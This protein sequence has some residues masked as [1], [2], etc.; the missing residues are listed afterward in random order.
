MSF[1][2]IT[3]NI[4]KNR[5]LHTVIPF[6]KKEK[7]DVLC[8][9][10]VYDCDFEKYK[11]VSGLDGVFIPMFKGITKPTKNTD[12]NVVQGNALLTN[13]PNNGIKVTTYFGDEN[14]PRFTTIA[15]IPRKL[16]YTTI[17]VNGEKYTIGTT[18]FTWTPDGE[19]DDP[20]RR[21]F[22]ELMKVL[23]RFDELILCGDF[24]APRGKEIF[25]KFE[26][27]FKDNIPLDVD[28]TLDLKLHK[29]APLVYVVDNIFTT[30]AY[31]VSNVR[32]VDGVSD[33]KAVIGEVDKAL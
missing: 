15:N 22:K 23:K 27:R 4:E 30:P 13:F 25:K 10:E 17:E 21:T 20:Q 5:H 14:V 28:T 2:L 11:E 32:V 3:L 7:P 8:L 19:A 18:H 9:Q 6:L 31:K 24:N 1:K 29:K 26:E 12:P 16:S 33:H